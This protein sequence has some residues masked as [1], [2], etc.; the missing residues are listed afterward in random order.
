[1][2]LSSPEDNRFFGARCI[3]FSLFPPHPGCQVVSAARF[4]HLRALVLH[5][6]GQPGPAALQDI[7]TG[8]QL[9]DLPTAQTLVAFVEHSELERNGGR[10]DT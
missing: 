1:M 5:D 2:L 6:L 9:H 8:P 7:L 10:K 4:W 3:R